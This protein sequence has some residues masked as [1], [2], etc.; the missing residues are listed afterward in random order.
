[1]LT[2]LLEYVVSFSE[3]TKHITLA[4]ILFVLLVDRIFLPLTDA[5]LATS[6]EQNVYG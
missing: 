2:V 6:F 1:M 5:F 4:Q 3:D